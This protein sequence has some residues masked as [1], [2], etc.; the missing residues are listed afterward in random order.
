MN[1]TRPLAWTSLAGALLAAALVVA[2][3]ETTS[4]QD[5]VA[6]P[7]NP[8]AEVAAG[9]WVRYR[10]F[11]PGD[12][13]AEQPG[14]HIEIVGVAGDLVLV[15]EANGTSSRYDKGPKGATAL[16]YLRGFLGASADDVLPGMQALTGRVEKVTVGEITYEAF[17]V[18]ARFVVG[19]D[20]ATAITLTLT[21]W[22][23][24]RVHAT[25]L[26]QAE[27]STE[28]AGVTRRGMLEL[29]ASG[30]GED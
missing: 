25:G 21:L 22:L 11:D 23:S 30:R 4:A 27:I 3:P 2:W 7:R 5:D 14:K 16:G 18:D 17:R 28:R 26:I 13:D 1:R 29:T 10:A 19:E 9:D 24:E 6:L 12:P 8:L 20:E 15:R